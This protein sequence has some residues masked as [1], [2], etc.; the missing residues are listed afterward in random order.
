M[1]D[2]SLADFENKEA[3]SFE[4]YIER[5]KEETLEDGE[6]FPITFPDNKFFE[7][8]LAN[9]ERLSFS[10]ADNPFFRA[11]VAKYYPECHVINGETGIVMAT[12][13]P[14]KKTCQNFTSMGYCDNFRDEKLKIN[15][16]R[17]IKFELSNLKGSGIMILLTVRTFDTRAEK[18]KEGAYDQA[19][20]R[21]QNEDTNQALDYTKV[22]SI[23]LPEGYD[24]TEGAAV[25]EEEEEGG[26]AAQGERNELIYIAGRIYLEAPKVS[27]RG[28]QTARAE[29]VQSERKSQLAERKPEEGD[30]DVVGVRSPSNMKAGEEMGSQRSQMQ[31]RGS[32]NRGVIDDLRNAKWVYERYNMVTTSG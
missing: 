15:D 30:G 19:W 5:Y 18:V 27:V 22:N 16:D 29:S 26:D 20:F 2:G 4:G 3:E 12:I 23:D 1:M 21:L 7:L 8:E 11:D 13:N 25:G 31:S 24:A 14:M 17:K 10:V 32:S 28:S 6:E 9:L